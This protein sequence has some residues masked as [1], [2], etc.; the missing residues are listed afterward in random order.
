MNKP[1]P[2]QVAADISRLAN[3][4]SEDDLNLVAEL[5]VNE[6]RT[7]QQNIMRG[8]VWPLLVAWSEDFDA[9]RYDA[10]NEATVKLAHD[11]MTSVPR[12]ALPTI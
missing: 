3:S 7:L 2:T 8:L 10:R 1:L 6:H 11:I 4:F 5:L 9:D 12:A